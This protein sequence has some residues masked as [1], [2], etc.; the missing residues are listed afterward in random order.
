[1]ILATDITDSTYQSL[2][3]TQKTAYLSQGALMFSAECLKSGIVEASIPSTLKYTPFRIMTLCVLISM[4]KDLVGS[5]FR[6]VRDGVTIDVYQSKLN[7]FN[8]ELSE[9]LTQFTP[10]M[11][12]YEATDD[13]SGTGSISVSYG[14]S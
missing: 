11:C 5:S 10:T 4:C 14:R 13:T 8:E 7:G 12:G 1:M 2:T 9:L 6:E 3:S